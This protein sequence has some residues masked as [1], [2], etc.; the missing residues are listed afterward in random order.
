MTVDKE[1]LYKLYMG[2]VNDVSETCDW[3]THFGPEEIVSAIA[4][5]IEEHP[6]LI[7]NN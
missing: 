2:W 4:R 7:L 1:G 6:E 3:K 5:I